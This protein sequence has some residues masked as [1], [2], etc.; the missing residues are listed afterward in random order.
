[1][2]T[3]YEKILRDRYG[4]KDRIIQAHLDYLEEVTPIQSASAEAL[5]TMYIECNRCIKALRAMG[6]DVKAYDRVLSQRLSAHSR[7][8]SADAGSSR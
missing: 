6:E 3:Y 5:N 8:I 2:R 4:D 7:T 1:M